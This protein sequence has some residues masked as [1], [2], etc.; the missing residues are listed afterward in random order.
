MTHC[1]AMK[2][3][4]FHHPDWCAPV[5]GRRVAFEL[6]QLLDGWVEIL[7]TR[8]RTFAWSRRDP[9][10][11]SYCAA[12]RR[13][14]KAGAIASRPG[15]RSPSVLKLLP[16][17]EGLL[18]EELRPEKFWNR[19]WNGIWY[20]LVY[21]VPEAQRHYRAALR[22]FLQRLRMGGLQGSVWVSPR[23]IRP[24]YAD[25]VEGAGAGEFA[26]LFEARTVLGQEA[27]EVVHM[28]WDMDRLDEAQQWY[29]RTAEANLAF[30]TAETPDSSTLFSLAREETSAF[31]S[32]MRS[33]P[34][35]P[36]SLWPLRYRGPEAIE[37]HR[38]FQRAVAARL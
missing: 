3:A 21:D 35:L 4:P 33:D 1:P 31:V 28:A 9:E 19:K 20:V 30:L 38:A 22:R 10:Y 15:G 6:L 24:D 29:L 5:V 16:E 2:W 14:R 37:M 13:L 8:G 34:L 36:R 26:V 12:L 11:W 32:V 17:S 7:A 27:R 18:P 23:D 25:L